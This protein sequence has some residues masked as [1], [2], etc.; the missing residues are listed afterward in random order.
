M[1]PIS[2]IHPRSASCVHSYASKHPAVDLDS[3]VFIHSD[4]SSIW[5][6]ALISLLL[7]TVLNTSL[8]S[9]YT[10]FHHLRCPPLGDIPPPTKSVSEIDGW[11][12]PSIQ[13]D[14]WCEAVTSYWQWKT[15]V[16]I[17]RVVPSVFTC[18][19]HPCLIGEFIR[20]GITSSGLRL[21][22]FLLVLFLFGLCVYMF[23]YIYIYVCLYWSVYVSVNARFLKL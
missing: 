6:F 3:R 4:L 14:F 20:C 9:S 16:G 5:P 13:F 15:S 18:F 1:H 2:C 7:S 22:C 21:G 8:C 12:G 17:W 11:N 23:G 10:W 19:M